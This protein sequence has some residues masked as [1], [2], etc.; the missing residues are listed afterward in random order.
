M[1]GRNW[2]RFSVFSEIA[3]QTPITERSTTCIWGEL[4]HKDN[5]NKTTAHT[6]AQMILT[7]SECCLAREVSPRGPR[8]NPSDTCKRRILVTNMTSA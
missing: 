3:I 6:M 5:I 7:F 4:F 1:N 2:V 8:M